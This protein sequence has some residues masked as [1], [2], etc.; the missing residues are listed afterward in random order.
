MCRFEPTRNQ[1]EQSA[2]ARAVWSNDA[3]SIAGF[4]F[5]IERIQNES[6]RVGP[7]KANAVQFDTF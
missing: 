5:M 2:F 3:E 4:K 7:R 6:A 1:I